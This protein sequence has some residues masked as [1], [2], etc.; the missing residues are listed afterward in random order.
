MNKT[1]TK[2][3]S[4]ILA[5]C[6]IFVTSVPGFAQPETNTS[7]LKQ[8]REELQNKLAQTDR[9]LAELGKKSKETEEY[10]ETLGDKI[11][12]LTKQYDYARQEAQ[13]IESRVS[14]LENS[15]STNEQKIKDM[16][17]EVKKLEQTVA[18]LDSE[19]QSDY[20]RYCSRM[21]AIYISN[22]QG[23]I[24]N[25]LLTSSSVDSFITRLQMISSV[26]KQDGEL[27]EKVQNQSARVTKTKEEL[28]TKARDLKK[29]QV[30]LKNNKT[31]LKTQRAALIEKQEK[32]E[33]QQAVIEA[34]QSEQNEIL[35]DLHDK[36]KKYGE[37]RNTT[38]EELDSIDADIAA[39]DRMFT[40][41]ET[42][43]PSTSKT[44][45][46]KPNT[47]ST[48]EPSTKPTTTAPKQ[49][50][51]I[52]LTYPCPE[53]KTI[54]CAFGA[55]DGH[56]GADF[57]TWGNVNCKIVAAESGTVILVKI[58]EYSYGH[59][60]VIRHDK[61]TASGKAVYTLYAHNNDILVSPGQY[62]KKGQQI[63]Y[64]GSTGNSTGPHCHFE[65][66]IGGPDQYCAQN[67]ANYLP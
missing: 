5:I 8:Q 56:T 9:K 44:P 17:V 13:N 47:A 28:K 57:S 64:S 1:L 38:K 27:L 35:K 39:A 55:Y 12:Y 42:T 4:V 6:V 16:G 3:M 49:S 67:P 26:A 10:I 62:V 46:K 15:I 23:S 65:V 41:S 51:Y 22:Q 29:T 40:Q 2:A 19:F 66:R 18:E 25:F 63:A 54:T 11:S 24:L 37:F 32:L 31:T 53:Y 45:R 21:R 30:R 58:L 61:K 36:T 48:T 33:E 60:I 52:S 7:S 59:Y 34:Q 20:A 50:E 43:A 14:E